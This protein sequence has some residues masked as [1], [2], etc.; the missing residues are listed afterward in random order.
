MA[1]PKGKTSKGSK[2]SKSS[3]PGL[4]VDINTGKPVGPKAPKSSLSGMLAA[5]PKGKKTKKGY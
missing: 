2:P 3:K 4:K 1:L 5:K